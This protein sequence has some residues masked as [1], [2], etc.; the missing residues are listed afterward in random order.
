MIRCMASRKGASFMATTNPI[1]TCRYIFFCGRHLLCAKLRRANIDASAGSV[2][3]VARIVAQIRER[4]PE[5]RILLRADSGFTRDDLMTWCEQNDIDYLFGLA[6]NDRL[7]AEENRQSGKPAR[8]FKDF[9]YRT[10]KS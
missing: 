1:V 6:K 3:E 9:Q 7:T 5:V 8:R 4:W 10:R 2:E